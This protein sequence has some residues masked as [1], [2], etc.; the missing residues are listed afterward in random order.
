MKKIFNTSYDFLGSKKLKNK[1]G[2]RFGY[3]KYEVN[4]EKDENDSIFTNTTLDSYGIFL[5][6]WKEKNLFFTQWVVR[7]QGAADTKVGKPHISKVPIQIKEEI[8]EEY[9]KEA[10]SK[11]FKNIDIEQV[12]LFLSKIYEYELNKEVKN[13]NLKEK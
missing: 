8:R 7:K 2:S 4:R 5:H 6:Y 11:K 1:P 13:R 12:E 3:I 9:L 10:I